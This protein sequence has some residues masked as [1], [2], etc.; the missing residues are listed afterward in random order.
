MMPGRRLLTTGVV[1]AGLALAASGGLTA[2]P[3]APVVRLWSLNAFD[4]LYVLS[5]GGSSA[6]ALM[7]DEGVVLIDPL[8]AGYGKASIEAIQA[9]SDQPVRTIINIRS[10]A[11][12]LKANLEYPDV[13]IVVA[14]R[15]VA[16][17]ASRLGIFGGGSEKFAPSTIVTEALTLLDGPDLMQLSLP[18]PGRTDG[19][20]LVVFPEKKLAYLGDLF[21]G[22]AVP[23]VERGAGGSLL[24]LSQTLART[25][26][27]VTGIRSAI[28][29]RE[30]PRAGGI[31]LHKPMSVMPISMTSQ[32]PP[33]WRPGR[34]RM[35][36][37]GRRD[38]QLRSWVWLS[39]LRATTS[40]V[41]PVR[42]WG[43]TPN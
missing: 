10:D 28:P 35:P 1:A 39:V 40:A 16:D 26:T 18:G 37:G 29:G 11:E 43:Y 27:E 12:H 3:A 34:R 21:P 32:W 25:R 38:R 30:S 24:S 31:G 4:I 7:R 9:V 41:R 19:D 13:S 36:R 6:V 42:W 2:Q 33:S 5:G 23:I 22:K 14:A 17:R 8:P 20:M 15:T